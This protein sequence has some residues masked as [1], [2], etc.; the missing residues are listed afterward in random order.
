MS[1]TQRPKSSSIESNFYGDLQATRSTASN[2]P[3]WQTGMNRPYQVAGLVAVLALLD[4]PPPSPPLPPATSSANYCEPPAGFIVNA[5]WRFRIDSD[6]VGLAKGWARDRAFGWTMTGRLDADEETLVSSNGAVLSWAKAPSVET[7][8]FD[9]ASGELASGPRS[10]VHFTL[11]NHRLPVPQWEWDSFETN[12][13]NV[14]FN[15]TQSPTVHWQITA[16]N[17]SD[18]EVGLILLVVVPPFSAAQA[19]VPI[20]AI[21]LQDGSRLWINGEPSLVATMPLDGAGVGSLAQVMAAAM[22]GQTPKEDAIVNTRAADGASVWTYPLHLGAGESTAFAFAFP[23][24]RNSSP[25]CAHLRLTPRARR[26]GLRDGAVAA[27]RHGPG[28]RPD[29]EKH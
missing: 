16:Q 23:S 11:A 25:N 15:D 7:R 28:R 1:E 20:C 14:R 19:M 26:A 13:R 12:L 21:S 10:G 3:D 6:D 17:S 8:L 4:R 27:P 22:L 29:V 2:G 5:G 18:T 24:A 9:P